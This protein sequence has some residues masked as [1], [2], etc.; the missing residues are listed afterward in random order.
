MEQKLT[1]A[2]RVVPMMINNRE[3]PCRLMS[4]TWSNSLPL[5][6]RKRHLKT[7]FK[8][9]FF[10]SWKTYGSSV[11]RNCL[12]V[13]RIRLDCI[14]WWD[15]D[16]GMKVS[17]SPALGRWDSWREKLLFWN[18]FMIALEASKGLRKML[19]IKLDKEMDHL[20]ASGFGFCS[21]G[22]YDG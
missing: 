3:V 1:T 5:H 2:C 17:T 14:E 6:Y 8:T 19:I 18:P 11:C 10:P 15:G 7:F 16:R 4:N 20:H 13:L 22:S 12:Q 21:A 9:T